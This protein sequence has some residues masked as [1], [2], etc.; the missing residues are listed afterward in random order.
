[1]AKIFRGWALARQGHSEEGISQLHEGLAAYRATG[2]EVD[3]PL[4]LTFLADACREG[5]RTEEGLTAVTEA[6]TMI[7][8]NKGNGISEAELYRLKG[9]LLLQQFKVQSSRFKVK[10]PQSAFPN[11]QLEA[12]ACFH[13]AIDLARQQQAKS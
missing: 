10:N 5:T 13:K 6:L 9:E 7:E 1:M 3:R 8:Q 4:L 2:A 12:E 11:P